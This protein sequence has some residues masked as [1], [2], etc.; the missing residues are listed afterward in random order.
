MA[1]LGADFE[2][3]GLLAALHRGCLGTLATAAGGHIEGAHQGIAA[4]K[5]RGIAL[6]SAIVLSLIHI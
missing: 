1:P 2:L 5:R 3:L 4:A 6:P